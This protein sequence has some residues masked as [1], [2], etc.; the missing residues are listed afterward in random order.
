MSMSN[1]ATDIRRN[2]FCD[3]GGERTTI[4][5]GEM[6]ARRFTC[7]DAAKSLTINANRRTNMAT[8]PQ[9]KIC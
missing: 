2:G 6:V 7:P 4:S 3:R 8:L 1:R 9:H 5:T